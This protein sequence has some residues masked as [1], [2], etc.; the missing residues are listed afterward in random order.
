MG[1]LTENETK[2]STLAKFFWVMWIFVAYFLFV[3][4]KFGLEQGFAVTALTWSFFVLCTPIAD[5]GFLLD[6]PIRLITNFKM[7]YTEVFV[8]IIAILLN[9]Y[10]VNYNIEIYEKTFLLDV[11]KHILVQPVPYWS[12]IILSGIG[13]FLS[14]YFGDELFDAV[15]HEERRKYFLHKQKLEIILMIFLIGIIAVIYDFLLSKLGIHLI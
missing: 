14:I 12:I 9:L 1:N 11:F 7:F 2:K 6:F 15:K 10:F 3:S 13:T 8:W 5:A 4:Y